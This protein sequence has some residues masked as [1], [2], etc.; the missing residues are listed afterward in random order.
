VMASSTGSNWTE[1]PVAGGFHDS[2]RFGVLCTLLLLVVV[3]GAGAGVSGD[4]GVTDGEGEGDLARDPCD[5][6]RTRPVAR[7]SCGRR[8]GTCACP[9]AAA[10]SPLP[11]GELGGGKRC[12]EG[13]RTGERVGLGLLAAAALPLVVSCCHGGVSSRASSSDGVGVW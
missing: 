1:M 2:V 3:T 4:G 12:C 8:P 10:S 5:G 11:V 13:R 9:A 7:R 6:V